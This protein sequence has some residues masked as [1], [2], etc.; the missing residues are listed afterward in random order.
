MFFI[1]GMGGGLVV[2]M[3]PSFVHNTLY[4]VYLHYQ[5]N[6]Q[7]FGSVLPPHPKA[8]QWKDVSLF[9][10]TI[11][12]FRSSIYISALTKTGFS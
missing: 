3:A 4:M 6:S 9:L 5:M 10:I 8:T 2:C 11:Q 7:E 12:T 1:G